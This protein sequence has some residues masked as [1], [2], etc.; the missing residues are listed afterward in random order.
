MLFKSFITK[1][2]PLTFLPH[3]WHTSYF[4]TTACFHYSEIRTHIRTTE[5]Y[6]RF[7]RNKKAKCV[8][9]WMSQFYFAKNGDAALCG[10]FLNTFYLCS[11]DRLNASARNYHLL[12]LYHAFYTMHGCSLWDI[13][14][15]LRPLNFLSCLNQDS[16]TAMCSRPTDL[17]FKLLPHLFWAN[18]TCVL[19]HFMFQISSA[20]V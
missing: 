15:R 1:N 11:M 9:A 13:L 18:C 17:I 6:M 3:K 19:M 10:G 16:C 12:H 7:N 20:I 5:W 4:T 14:F 8:Q 2:F